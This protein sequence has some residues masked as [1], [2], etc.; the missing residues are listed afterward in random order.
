MISHK[1]SA[2]PRLGSIALAV[3]IMAIAFFAFSQQAH[4]ANTVSA[5][6]YQDTNGDGTVDRIRWTMDENVTACAYEAGDWTVN[7][8][9]T[10]NV[11]AITGLSCTG[12]DA[13]LNIAVTTSANITGGATDPVISYANAGTT[14]SVTLTSGA[15]TAKNSQTNTDAAAPVV[16]STSPGNNA[17]GVLTTANV[18]ITFSEPMATA[19]AEAT[20]FTISP[21]PGSFAAPAW[22]S[23]NTIVTLNPDTNFSCGLSYTFTTVEAQI[24]ASAGTPTTLVTTGPQDGDW[25]F[26][27]GA[28]GETTETAAAPAIESVSY[29][30]ANCDAPDL[31]SFTVTGTD[32]SGYISSTS[33]YFTG[34]VTTTQSIDG[35][36]TVTAT[37]GDGATKGYVAFISDSNVNSATYTMDLTDWNSACASS[38]ETPTDDSENSD[39]S[40]SDSSGGSTVPGVNPGD[41]ITGPST[42]AVYYVTTDYTRRVFLNEATFFTWYSNFDAVKEVSDDTLAALP[43][44]SSMLPKAGVVLVKIQSSP[45]VYALEDGVDMTTNLREIPDEATAISVYGNAWADYVIDVEPTFFTK[46]GMGSSINSSY[47]VDRGQMK[48]RVDLHS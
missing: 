10:I 30:G 42:T 34:G 20:E 47:S 41:I 26:Y 6:V 4:A 22:T 11:T 33:K 14:G 13:F 23:G 15:M 32:I 46:F 28:C 27:V 36:A 37:F 21:D 40:G 5:A 9:G 12:S 19:F 24:D 7:T 8:A 3:G 18:V 38:T 25:T 45:V 35:S 2:L 29:L 17:A 31:H 39:D 1:I 48:R 43:L 44:G 16:V